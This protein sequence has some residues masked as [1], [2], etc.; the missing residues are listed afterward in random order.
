MQSLCMTRWSMARHMLCFRGTCPDRTPHDKALSP[1]SPRSGLF[2]PPCPGMWPCSIF[3]RPLRRLEV[4]LARSYLSISARPGKDIG[5]LER[6]SREPSYILGKELTRQ[7]PVGVFFFLP[8]LSIS[9]PYFLS[10]LRIEPGPVA[11]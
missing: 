2:Y 1:A 5:L 8:F 3:V 11:C 4:Y 10:V 7:E 9:F 6:Y